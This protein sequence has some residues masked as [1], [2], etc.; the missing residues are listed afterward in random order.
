MPVEVYP[1]PQAVTLGEIWR[2]I[3]TDLGGT[4]SSFDMTV[5]DSIWHAIDHGLFRLENGVFGDGSDG[6]VTFN[7][8]STIL[9]LAPTNSTYTL[10]RD[11]Y[12]AGATVNTGVTIVTAGYRIFCNGVLTLT[13]TAN[14]N[15]NGN[16][17]A[18]NGSAG[19]AIAAAVVGGGTAGGAGGANNGTAGATGP[20]AG[21]GGNGGAGGNS[22][23]GS[24]TDGGAGATVTAPTNAHGGWRN[25]ESAVNAAQQAGATITALQG[26]AGGGGGAGDGT[27]LGG[28]GGSGAGIVLVC[29]QSI[30]GSGTITATGGAG[31][32]GASAG[33]TGGGAGGG[34]GL[35][36]I[37]SRT[38]Y[39]RQINNQ[40]S[41]YLG[42]GTTVAVTAVGGAGGVAH[43]ANGLNGAAGNNGTTLLL[44]G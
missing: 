16:G 12:L 4:P 39:P 8:T 29:A 30:Q 26:G 1:N 18:N 42:G 14:I 9:G 15:N 41:P 28:G 43:G 13:G 38:V 23:N 3:F 24:V 33:N 35:V 27:N 37:I 36:I 6:Y 2:N 17:G 7:G 11:L 10:T 5:L 44:G 20:V 40:T 21:A 31:G 34:G 19:A 22:N 25:I 32:N